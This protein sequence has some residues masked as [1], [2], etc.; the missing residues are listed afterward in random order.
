MS[1]PGHCLLP[2]LGAQGIIPVGD[3]QLSWTTVRIVR[4]GASDAPD[5]KAPD[6]NVPHGTD[7]DTEPDV[8]EEVEV[9]GNR[10]TR[11]DERRRSR[12]LSAAVAPL[13]VLAVRGGA[14]GARD[15]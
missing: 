8:I 4:E 11:R 13:A 5:D 15:S 10:L 1:V 12:P 7:D 9:L 6:D 14:P 3:V 2:D